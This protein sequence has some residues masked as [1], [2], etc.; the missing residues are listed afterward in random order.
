MRDSPFLTNNK[1]YE[2][3]AWFIDEWF[4]EEWFMY[5]SEGQAD[6][7]ITRLAPMNVR[8]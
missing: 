5:L 6:G 7:A 8:L 2:V 4:I 3:Y 1:I